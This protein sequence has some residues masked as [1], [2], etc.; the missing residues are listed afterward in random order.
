[1]KTFY[2]LGL[3]DFRYAEERYLTSDGN[4]YDEIYEVIA[5]SFSQSIEK[6]FKHIIAQLGETPPASHSLSLLVHKAKLPQF[7]RDAKYYT[8]IF[9]TKRYP[10]EDF[11]EISY[12]DLTELWNF[13]GRVRDYAAS[14]RTQVLHTSNI[15]LD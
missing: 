3:L 11:V 1:M 6:F 15:F 8:D 4:E 12:D 14:V 7:T 10:C 9:F 2:D 5:V 13:A